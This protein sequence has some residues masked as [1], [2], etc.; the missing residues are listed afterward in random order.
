MSNEDMKPPGGVSVSCDNE[1]VM[2]G[3]TRLE[4]RT[5]VLLWGNTEDKTAQECTFKRRICNKDKVRGEKNVKRSQVW[6]AKKYGYGWSTRQLVR[7]TCP[8]GYQM[9]L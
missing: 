6:T 5:N 4:V 8:E 1:I 2:K 7:Y 9:S 3:N